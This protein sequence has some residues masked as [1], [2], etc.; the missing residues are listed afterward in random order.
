MGAKNHAIVMPDGMFF[1]ILSLVVQK[2]S[3]PT[4]ISASTRSSVP[5]L[6]LQ[7]NAVWP[8]QSVRAFL[9]MNLGLDLIS[10]SDPGWGGSGLA[11][12]SCWTRSKTQ[13]DWR[14]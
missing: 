8:S 1:Q 7:G 2:L 12:G 13:S 9:P 10:F 5:H 14:F 4:R 3:Q 11:S 6:V